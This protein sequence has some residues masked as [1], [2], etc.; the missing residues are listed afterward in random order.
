MGILPM[1]RNAHIQSRRITFLHP[2]GSVAGA[3]RPEELT[4]GDEQRDIELPRGDLTDILYGLTQDGSIRY[5]FNDSIA[6]LSDDGTGVSVSVESGAAGYYDV[7]VGADGIH[8]RA[9]RV[10]FGPEQPFSH[11]L[12]YCYNGFS[13]P[14]WTARSSTA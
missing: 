4:G 13:T 14:N 6:S 3:I 7:V 8:S 5:Q 11:Y 10:V 2:D 12:G 1:L 9:R